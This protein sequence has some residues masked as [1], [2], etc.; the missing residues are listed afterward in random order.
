MGGAPIGC[1]SVTCV[2]SNGHRIVVIEEKK[3]ITPEEANLRPKQDYLTH[4]WP[5]SSDVGVSQGPSILRVHGPL[6]QL[7]VEDIT[8]VNTDGKALD[9]AVYR[10]VLKVTAGVSELCKNILMETSCANAFKS[11]EEPEVPREHRRAMLVEAEEGADENEGGENFSLPSGWKALGSDG[12]G[13]AEPVP[14]A[15]V[16][17]PGG[18]AYVAVHLYRPPPTSAGDPSTADVDQCTTEYEV[19]FSYTQILRGGKEKAVRRR[20]QGFLENR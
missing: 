17:E 4:T 15:E 5:A 2:L 9:G 16:L 8:S 18:V 13:T 1:E 7:R 11:N 12:S 14:I 6:A 19:V 3:G 20:C 10:V